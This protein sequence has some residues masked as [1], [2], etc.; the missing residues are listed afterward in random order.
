MSGIVQSL[1]KEHRMP[2]S[3][4]AHHV[5]AA[6]PESLRINLGASFQHKNSESSIVA[7]RV[8]AAFSELHSHAAVP[9]SSKKFRATHR[10]YC[11][12]RQSPAHA[13]SQLFASSACQLQ[14]KQSCQTTI[15]TQQSVQPDRRE[16]APPG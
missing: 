6:T 10:A 8:S 5:S 7:R 2:T 13:A 15:A 16:D 4:I 12:A 3:V 14:V 9:T 1:E 11:F